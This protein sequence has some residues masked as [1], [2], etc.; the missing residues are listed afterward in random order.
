MKDRKHTQ[1]ERKKIQTKKE[2][3]KK[4]SIHTKTRSTTDQQKKEKFTIYIF[5]NTQNWLAIFC[6]S[7]STR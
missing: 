3:R 1:K 7:V 2:K 5:E 4:E 6:R